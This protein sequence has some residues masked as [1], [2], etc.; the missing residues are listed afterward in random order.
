MTILRQQCDSF[1]KGV[2]GVSSKRS[3]QG[4]WIQCGSNLHLGMINSGMECVQNAESAFLRW[5]TPWGLPFVSV[6][7][8]IMVDISIFKTTNYK[9]WDDSCTWWGCNYD[10]TAIKQPSKALSD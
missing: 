4:T 9:L 8:D 6:K 1:Y 7:Y 2:Q 10:Y 3:A 5:S